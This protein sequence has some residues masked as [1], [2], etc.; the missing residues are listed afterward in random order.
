MW[1]HP[2][3]P[4]ALT[5]DASGSF[6]GVCSYTAFSLFTSHANPFPCARAHVASTPTARVFLCLQNGPA[7]L[8]AAAEAL[9]CAHALGHRRLAICPWPTEKGRPHVSH[10][11]HGHRTR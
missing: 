1:C 6:R 7:L 11:G 2:T 9:A 8:G 5:G 3:Q 4:T 10:P